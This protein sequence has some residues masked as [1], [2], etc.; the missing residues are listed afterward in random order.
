[1]RKHTSAASA[2]KSSGHD[3]GACV[4]TLLGRAHRSFE[5]QGLKLTT[6]RLQVLKEIAASHD[7]VGAYD[8]IDRVA[9]KSGD[10]LAPISVY[11][12]IDALQQAGLVH[13]LESRNAYFAC[14]AQHLKSQRHMALVCDI[15]SKI[16]EVPAGNLYDSIEAASSARGFQLKS[17][18]AE[19]FGI[20]AR[21]SADEGA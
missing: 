2:S 21:C 18:V 10:K 6:L 12:A 19:G 3:H 9:K 5:E 20:C 1:M 4:E 14:H 17:A 16:T 13:R 8:V 11:R 7:A 15:C